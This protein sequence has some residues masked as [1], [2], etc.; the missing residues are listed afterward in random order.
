MNNNITLKPCPFCGSTNIHI[1]KMG[2]PHWI[3]CEDCGAKIHGRQIGEEEGEKASAEAWNRRAN[4]NEITL[5]EA[6]KQLK[7]IANETGRNQRITVMPGSDEITDDAVSA[8]VKWLKVGYQEHVIDDNGYKIDWRNVSKSV[9][10]NPDG[11]PVGTDL[12]AWRNASTILPPDDA[13]VLCLTQTKSG[14][15][16]YVLGYYAADLGRWVCGMNSNVKYWMDMPVPPWEEAH[17]E[18]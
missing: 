7:Q 9:V 4:E 10:S 15:F 16:N 17:D 1:M 13:K 18:Q 6:M 8:F 2:Y 5:S 12:L 3:Y 14:M 11:T